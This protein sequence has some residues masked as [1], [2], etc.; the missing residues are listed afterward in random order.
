MISKEAQTI[1]TS[2]NP[3]QGKKYR[4]KK[5]I[6]GLARMVLGKSESTMPTY[7]HPQEATVATPAA[8]ETK[9]Y[10]SETETKTIELE[11]VHDIMNVIDSLDTKL[12]KGVSLKDAAYRSYHEGNGRMSETSQKI[13]DGVSVYGNR[14]ANEYGRAQSIVLRQG[15]DVVMLA[16]GFEQDFTDD[17]FEAIQYELPSDYELDASALVGSSELSELRKEIEQFAVAKVEAHYVRE[18]TAD[19]RDDGDAL[20]TLDN[21]LTIQGTVKK[22]IK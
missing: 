7:V 12:H 3:E 6:L 5:A 16:Q 4:S 19:T 15:N 13:I 10:T 22:L 21:L 18:H 11:L 2:G 20:S 17:H 9:A 14:Y 1:S 8:P